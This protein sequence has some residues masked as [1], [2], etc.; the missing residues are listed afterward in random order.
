V[1]TKLFVLRAAGRLHA[2]TCCC[3]DHEVRNGVVVAPLRRDR[4]DWNIGLSVLH[5]RG[6]G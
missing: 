3:L 5:G 6:R 1:K 4:V 2:R